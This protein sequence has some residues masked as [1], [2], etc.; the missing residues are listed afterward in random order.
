M[1]FRL[2]LQNVSVGVLFTLGLSACDSH[3]PESMKKQAQTQRS[4]EESSAAI[5]SKMIKTYLVKEFL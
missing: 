1:Q 4:S 3:H 2:F 5:I